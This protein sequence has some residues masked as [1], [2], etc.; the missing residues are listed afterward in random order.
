MD[1]KDNVSHI[2][3]GVIIA[4]CLLT[5]VGIFFLK[6]ASDRR[7]PVY[8]QLHPEDSTAMKEHMP[9]AVPDTS[10]DTTY[11]P[12]LRDSVSV[13]ASDSITRDTRGAYEAGSE[14]GYLAGMDDGATN[15]PHASYD[16]SNA[17]TRVQDKATYI[18][19]YKEGYQ[20]GFDDGSHG[21]Q[22]NIGN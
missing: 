12:L 22:F 9:V 18:R 6:R 11:M 16:T 19:G 15:H 1:R 21:K 7:S 20:K 14:D 2:W 13:A 3:K 4:V 17:F 5:V 10:I 8:V